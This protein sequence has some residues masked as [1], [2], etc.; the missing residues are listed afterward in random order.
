MH[1]P[2]RPAQAQAWRKRTAAVFAAVGALIFSSGIVMLSAPAANAAEVGICHATGSDSQPYNFI[3]VDDSSTDLNGHKAHA[4]DS[5][6]KWGKDGAWWNGTWYPA[7]TAKPDLISGLTYNGTVTAA[8]CALV[9][10]NGPLDVTPGVN[11]VNPACANDNTPSWSGVNADKVTYTVTSGSVAPLASVVVTAAPKAGYTFPKKTDPTFDWDY[12]AALDCRGTVSP[13][14]PQVGQPACTGPGTSSDLVVTLATAPAGISYGYNAATRTV[15]A[16]VTDATKKLAATLGADWVRVSDTTATFAVPLT[17]AGACLVPVSAVAA[18]STDPSCT[19]DG[20]LVLPSSAD[21][22]YHWTGQTADVP[23]DHTVTAVADAGYVLT[24]QVTWTVHVPAAREGLECP[25]DATIVT[26]LEPTWVEARCTSDADVDYTEVTGVQY[27]TSGIPGPGAS[28]T[29]TASPVGNHAFAGNAVTSWSHTFQAKPAGAACGGVTP[30]PVTPK[31]EP[32][33]TLV[34]PSYPSATDADCS[35]DGQL[36][37]PA[38]PEGVLTT[39]SGT[40]PGAVTFTF[41]PAAGYAFP[42]GTA[43]TT[44]VTVAERLSGED[45]I[46]GVESVKPKPH[47]TEPKPH[48]TKPR[49]KPRD[50]APIVLGTQAAVPTAVDAGLAGLP[51]ATVS[52]TSSPRLAQALVAG[53]L[54]MLVAGGSLGLGRRPRGAHES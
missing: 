22:G 2:H 35:N 21:D 10:T 32:Q 28:V 45:C 31:P 7:G 53:G 12:T 11:F 47:T 23:G 38:Q 18:S 20:H 29:V 24:G 46:L 44:T 1:A 17:P 54:L 36:V 30:T 27:V 4:V 43:T 34:T 19:V 50:R 14:A 42:A 49:P 51:G 15:T 3:G 48:T 6:F 40:A 9:G 41:A 5:G 16:T 52:P 39:R 13:Q 26:P 8:L 25:G 33:P 37:V